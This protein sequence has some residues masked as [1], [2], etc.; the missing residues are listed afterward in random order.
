VFV[1]YASQDA[2]AALRIAGALRTAGIE[3]W[4]DQSELRGGDAWDR[5][6]R[7]LIREC[8]LFVAVISAN[9]QARDEGYFRRE[10]R[11]AVDR[12]HDM[13]ESKA[14]LVPVVIDATPQRGA[15]VPDKFRDIQWTY[16]PAGESSPEFIARIARL[17]SPESGEN[18]PQSPRASSGA[19]P[20]HSLRE[21]AVRPE[22]VAA[23]G[24]RSPS[25]G[26]QQ[27]EPPRSVAVLPF[28]NLSSDREQEYFSDGLTEELINHLAHVRGLRVLARTSS[29]V[30]KGKNEDLRVI[31]QKLGV[32]CVVEGSVRKAGN[33]LRITAQLVDC[34]DGYHLW[35]ETFDRELDDVFAIQ[36][37]ISK[38]VAS[39]LGIALV[40]GGDTTAGGT[41]NLEAYD[42]YLRGRALYRLMAPVE[43]KRAADLFRQALALDPEFALAWIGLSATVVL[44]GT[45][46]P[47]TATQVERES[48]RAVERA[49]SIAPTLAAAHVANIGYQQRRH[50]WL[51]ADESFRKAK[52][53]AS[54]V[55]EPAVFCDMLETVGRLNE[56]ISEGRLARAADPLNF[57]TSSVLQMALTSAG[58]FDEADKEYIRSQG[59]SGNR[60]AIEHT[61]V[62]RAWARGL[63]SSDIRA[64]IQRYL[65]HAIPPMPVERDLAELLDRP[66]VARERL[67]LAS[68]DP[69]YQD[70]TRQFKIATWAAQ[71]GDVDLALGA[72]R[73]AFID[74]GSRGVSVIWLPT[75]REVRKDPRFK[76]LLRDLRIVDY[77]R[78]SGKWGDFARP[79]GHDDFEV[80]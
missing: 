46:I 37:D 53:L 32:G 18:G 41:R 23:H 39:A 52:G 17:L 69:A 48:G 62:I 21:D 1:S 10:W 79:L 33:R 60:T 11:L 15:S 24:Q 70:P 5:Q 68:E 20:R 38:S 59:L 80:S 73:R 50:H 34:A 35:S 43:L 14:F 77:W 72:V 31:G 63:A 42:L 67:R 7:N 16:L 64:S 4:L 9:T 47:E 3:V 61:A 40:F 65:E 51:E 71:F 8:R 74:M 75:Y 12:T 76:Q 29:F 13:S 27:R 45:H 2:A 25:S 49:L 56:A 28:A 57:I 36:D 54:S 26:M 78:T 55:E 58:Q 19:T 22:P 44:M 30:F 6:I 66:D